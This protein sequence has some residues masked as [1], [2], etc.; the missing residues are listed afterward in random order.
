[1]CEFYILLSL[2]ICSSVRK[3]VVCVTEQFRVT[4]G[5]I[6]RYV[7]WCDVI[8]V[9]GCNEVLSRWIKLCIVLLFDCPM[10][11]VDNITCVCCLFFVTT[12]CMPWVRWLCEGVSL[13]LRDDAFNVTVEGLVGISRSDAG[14]AV[15]EFGKWATFSV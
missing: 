12:R 1:M 7:A 4:V 10:L 13:M 14:R 15:L 9:A 11:L 8:Q 5:F 3:L 6:L 2:V